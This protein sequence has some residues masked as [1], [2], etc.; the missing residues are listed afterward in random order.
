VLAGDG[1]L[2]TALERQAADLGVDARFL[3]RRTDVPALLARADVVVSASLAEGLSNTVMEAMA[4]GRPVIGTDVGGTG[5]LL[6]D[7]GILVPPADPGALADAL[8]VLLADAGTGTRLA[9]SARAWIERNSSLDAMVDRHL[10][11]YGRLA[12]AA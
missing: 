5:E 6:R 11:L 3:G 7:R 10:E 2:R 9:A 1:P 4:A 12:C 8:E